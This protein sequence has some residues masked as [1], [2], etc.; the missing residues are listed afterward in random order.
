MTRPVL[1]RYLAAMRRRAIGSGRWSPGPYS[2]L[3]RLREAAFDGHVCFQMWV[4]I[5]PEETA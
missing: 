5:K 3:D 2:L 1:A 4:R